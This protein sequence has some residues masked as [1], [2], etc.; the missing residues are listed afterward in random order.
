VIDSAAAHLS[1]RGKVLVVE[2]EAIIAMDMAHILRSRGCQI[3]ALVSSG[4]ESIVQAERLHPDLVF[5]DVRL[6]GAINGL[7]A[8]R[9][10]RER[11]RIP[12][13]YLTAFGEDL[14]AMPEASGN[15]FP[16]VLKPF[17]EREIE[18]VLRRFLP[19]SGN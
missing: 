4:E 19:V 2:D 1:T 17:V 8:G 7:Q 9:E 6:K 3:A 18:S 11:F 14:A 13:V 5:M 12:V 16:R 10:I 15:D